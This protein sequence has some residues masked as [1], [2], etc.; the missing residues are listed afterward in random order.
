LLKQFQRLQKNQA[1]DVWPTV[2]KIDNA[3][4]TKI[5]TER[6]SIRCGQARFQAITLTDRGIGGDRNDAYIL[7]FLH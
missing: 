2:K 3:L 7:Y 5:A 1:P 6:S 4:D